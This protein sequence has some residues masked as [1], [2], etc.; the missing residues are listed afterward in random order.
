MN[1]LTSFRRGCLTAALFLSLT[2]ISGVSAALTTA[3][4]LTEAEALARAGSFEAALGSLQQ[5][6]A[7]DP[8][9]VVALTKLAGVQTLMG[10][11][12]TSVETYRK[13]LAMDDKHAPAYMGLG[14]ALLHLGDYAQAWLALDRAESL[15][16]ERQKEIQ[17]VKV[18]LGTKAQ[19]AMNQAPVHSSR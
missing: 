2:G 10:Q 5:T 4:R 19:A 12:S 1:G 13:A 8:Q 16:P 14:I 11:Y 15:A 6:V 7:E 9:S 18:W 17:E 3:E